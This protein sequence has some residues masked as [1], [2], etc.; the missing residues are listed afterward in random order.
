MHNLTGSNVTIESPFQGFG[1][2]GDWKP[3]ALPWAVIK[4]RRWRWKMHAHTRASASLPAAAG[5]RNSP[6]SSLGSSASRNSASV[7]DS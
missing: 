6:D 5:T 3:R 4:A 7:R 2:N 1:I